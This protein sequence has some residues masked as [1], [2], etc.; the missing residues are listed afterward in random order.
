MSETQKMRS[1]NLSK[2]KKK[3]SSW[4]LATL[5]MEN[6]LHTKAKIDQLYNASIPSLEIEKRPFCKFLLYGAVRNK[7]R[8][9]AALEHCIRKRPKALVLSIFYTTGYELLASPEEKAGA[10]IHHA[11]DQ[12]KALVSS[13]EVQFINAVLRKLPRH[14]QRQDPASSLTTYYSHPN[15]LVSRWIK[16]FGQSETEDL[17]KWNQSIPKIHLLA[18]TLPN[19]IRDV[20]DFQPF[21]SNSKSGN[22]LFKDLYTLTE[23]S[24][25]N[26]QLKQFLSDGNGYIKDP[27]TLHAVEELNPQPNESILDLCAAPGGKSFDCLSRMGDS[28][29]L[30]AIDYKAARMER[31]KQNLAAFNQDAFRLALIDCDILKL[32]YQI[33][34]DRGLPTR[35]DGILL[36]APCS[37]TGVIQ[38]K[39]DVRW[40]LSENSIQE[41]AALQLQLLTVASGL[42]VDGGRLVYSTCSI[43]PRENEGVINGFLASKAGQ[44]FVLDTQQCFYPWIDG[45]DG[46]GVFRL[47]KKPK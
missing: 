9:D 1:V 5:L 26:P 12:S 16:D 14:F 38:R 30:V 7:L 24:L 31:L 11:V 34:N 20:I 25:H 22:K 23:S 10:I 27:S 15:W 45:H 39:P 33:F 46:A 35:Y 44:G 32:N 4:V 42:L 36:D 28:G 13:K 47:L 3:K 2:N 43:D 19:A 8:I 21:I 37:N 18:K 6:Y 17:L 29:T 40:R 41:S